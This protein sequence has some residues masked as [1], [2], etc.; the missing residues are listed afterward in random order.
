MTPAALLS[1]AVTSLRL[2]A[3]R[4]ALT[5][6][7]VIIG[8]AGIIVLGAAGGGAEKMIEKQIT[9]IG[10]NTLIVSPIKATNA[11]QRGPIVLLTDEDAK[12]IVERVPDIQHISREV[13]G[14][15]TIV[16]GNTSW[17]PRILGCRR[18]LCRCFRC[19]DIGGPVFRRRRGSLGRQGR[20]ARRD[21]CGK[22]VRAMSRRLIKLCAWAACPCRSLACVH[23]SDL[24]A[25]KIMTITLSFQSRRHAR[26]CRKM[27]GPRRIS[28]T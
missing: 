10:A 7:G 4:S 11:G 24:L 3:L 14:K 18:L 17:T 19:D 2:N 6:I 21:G 15:V 22:T 9:A 27:I 5:A 20:R 25:D 13:D 28:S 1:E 8:V 23:N 26:G 12:A 16:A